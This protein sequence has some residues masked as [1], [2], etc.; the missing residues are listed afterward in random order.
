MVA[1]ELPGSELADL[2]FAV[3]EAAIRW[4]YQAC[5]QNAIDD[6]LWAAVEA[7]LKAREK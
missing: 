5:S 4:R 3:V 7:L 1:G 2:E 6:A